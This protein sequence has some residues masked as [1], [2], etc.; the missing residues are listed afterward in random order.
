MVGWTDCVEMTGLES[1]KRD[2]ESKPAR[3]HEWYDHG[4]VNESPKEATDHV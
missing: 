4:G 3:R 1:E 2:L